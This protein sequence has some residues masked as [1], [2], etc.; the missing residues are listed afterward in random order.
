MLSFFQRDVLDE[1]LDLTESVSEGFSTYPHIFV[2]NDIFY[3]YI[4]FVNLTNSVSVL[5]NWSQVVM[6]VSLHFTTYVISM[7]KS[8]L[9]VL[10]AVYTFNTSGLKS[11]VNNSH[12]NVQD[13]SYHGCLP[14]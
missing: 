6:S 13:I 3:T 2:K 11:F 12:L 4:M 1:I 7:Y 14:P 8:R 9:R 5:N 10:N